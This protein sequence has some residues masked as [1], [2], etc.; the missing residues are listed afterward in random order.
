MCIAAATWRKLSGRDV[1]DQLVDLEARIRNERQTEA[2]LREL[3][4]LRAQSEA[5]DILG[6]ILKV[7]QELGR[8]REQIE[9]MEAQREQ[10]QAMASLA[11]LRVVISTEHEDPKIEP[12]GI[13]DEFGEAAQTGLGMLVD[14]VAWLIRGL[15]GGLVWWLALGLGGVFLYTRVRWWLTWA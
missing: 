1:S 12:A 3:L 2:E 7:R 6:D 11:C 14:S 10:I 15:I 4:D 9:R 8:V 5:K 13:F